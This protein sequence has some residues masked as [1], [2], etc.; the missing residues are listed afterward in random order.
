[1]SLARRQ[2]PRAKAKADRGDTEFHHAPKGGRRHGAVDAPE[3]RIE[4]GQLALR[5]PSRFLR[6]ASKR[7]RLLGGPHL[8]VHVDP[9]LQLLEVGKVGFSEDHVLVF[10]DRTEELR[11]EFQLLEL[12]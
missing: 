9:C 8:G 7:A 3:Q 1:M 4:N 10:L 12:V 5:S 6:A 11:S 2:S